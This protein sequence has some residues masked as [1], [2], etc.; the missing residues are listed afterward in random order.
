MQGNSL[1]IFDSFPIVQRLSSRHS[2]VERRGSARGEFGASVQVLEAHSSW[3]RDICTPAPLYLPP[4][5]TSS[6][7]SFTLH[8]LSS[9]FSYADTVS[10]TAVS[11]A[12]E[13]RNTIQALISTVKEFH[14]DRLVELGLLV[15]SV[16]AISFGPFLL[17][18]GPAGI[19][20]IFSRLFPFQRGLNHAYWAP[21]IWALVSAVDRVLVKC[22]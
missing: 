6:T 12:L 11:G 5:S 14:L 10:R 1:A 16:F 17:A 8:H 20:Q 22:E 19:R 4:S 21:N 3:R 13:I 7:S 9:S 18:S 2:A 15:G